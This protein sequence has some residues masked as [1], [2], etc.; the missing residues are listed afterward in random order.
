MDNSLNYCQYLP[1]SIYMIEVLKLF[2]IVSARQ[3][4]KSVAV[5]TFKVDEEM[6]FKQVFLLRINQE[7]SYSVQRRLRS[8]IHHNICDM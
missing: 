6:L 4:L 2:V 3:V 5:K 8:K 7:T 1:F